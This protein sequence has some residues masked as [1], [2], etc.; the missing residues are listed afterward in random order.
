MDTGVSRGGC[1]GFQSGQID[2]IV[3]LLT[4]ALLS[5]QTNGL[6]RLFRKGTTTTTEIRAMQ[7]QTILDDVLT[8]FESG[9]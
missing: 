4:M 7:T 6:S 9:G 5:S 1:N 8:A 2:R 3:G